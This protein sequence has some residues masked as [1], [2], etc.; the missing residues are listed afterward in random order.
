MYINTTFRKQVNRKSTAHDRNSVDCRSLWPGKN[1][2]WNSAYFTRT[3][4]FCQPLLPQN[5]NQISSTILLSIQPYSD[6]ERIDLSAEKL[7]AYRQNRIVGVIA[8]VEIADIQLWKGHCR[9]SPCTGRRSGIS[10]TPH[11]PYSIHALCIQQ[12][13]CISLYGRGH[14]TNEINVSS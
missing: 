8:E 4:Y 3:G 11:K 2:W 9:V 5:L 1:S 13:T 12:V 10:E 6:W 14:E 7:W